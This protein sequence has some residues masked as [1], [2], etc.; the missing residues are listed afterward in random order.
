MY[1]V[2]SHV[3]RSLSALVA[4]FASAL[5]SQ[6][7]DVA[8]KEPP[9]AL[10]GV[11]TQAAI[12]ID[13]ATGQTLF[14]FGADRML[15]PA[16]T[17]KLFSTAA[18][19]LTEGAEARITTK[20]ALA[21][22]AQALVVRGLYDPSVD[23][24]FFRTDLLSEA[25]QKIVQRLKEKGVSHLRYLVADVS[26][27]LTGPYCPKRVWE[28]MGNHYGATPTVL[29]TDDNAV[30]VFF[31]SPKRVGEAC[32]IDSIVPMVEGLE[33]VNYVTS[34][35]GKSDLCYFYLAGNLWY[36]EG[37]IPVNRK[38][39]AVRATMPN[40]ETFYLQKLSKLL[41]DNGI[42]VDAVTLSAKTDTLGRT[43]WIHT[44]KSAPMAEIVRQCNLWSVN[45]IADALA[46]R[47]CIANDKSGAP[48]SWGSVGDWLS[49]FWEERIGSRPML[50]DGSG[51]SPFDAVSPRQ[52][53][54]LL[55]FMAKSD[56]AEAFRLSLPVVG[57]TGTVKSLA[58][59]T[60]V[61]GN[62]RAKS[63]TMTGVKSYAGYLT[64]E[65]GRDVAFA[66][67]VNHHAEKASALN[68]EVTKWLAALRNDKK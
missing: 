65:S 21:D 3:M 11:E 57:Q 28:D 29:M 25:A 31:S 32:S 26:S 9:L 48:L 53:A 30:R 7:Q 56:Q 42:D 68:A 23:S 12:A 54:S 14:D 1:H 62:A 47:G 27:A 40:P 59:N 50:F 2:P 39:F 15:T 66:I 63:G 13:V 58:A 51:L 18:A 52:L 43:T 20:F 44:H 35:S 36:A 10:S 64:T 4:L 17:C 8:R 55:L 24:R 34:Y 46:I 16:S 61:A 67:I 41:N 19:L 5:L 37:Q 60:S 38:A 49:G 22:D 6:A 45:L 33:P